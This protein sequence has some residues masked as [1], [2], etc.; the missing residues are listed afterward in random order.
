MFS[1]L[2]TPVTM[3]TALVEIKDKAGYVDVMQGK[4]M[5]KSNVYI[6]K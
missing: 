6:F 1:R 3:C 4:F 2:N 5:E